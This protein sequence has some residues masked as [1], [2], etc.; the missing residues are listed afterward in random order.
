MQEEEEK[1]RSPLVPVPPGLKELVETFTAPL[2]E[3]S[4]EAP[5]PDPAVS[6]ISPGQSSA[7][8]FVD[9]DD[10]FSDDI[11]SSTGHTYGP[12]L[13]SATSNAIANL[14]GGFARVCGA[15]SRPGPTITFEQRNGL[16]PLYNGGD[17]GSGGRGLSRERSWHSSSKSP[18]ESK[19]GSRVQ[20]T[21]QEYAAAKANG[22]K[23]LG[24]RNGHLSTPNITMACDND[25][26]HND[27]LFTQGSTIAG[28][29]LVRVRCWE[30][31]CRDYTR[32]LIRPLFQGN[33]QRRGSGTSSDAGA[34]NNGGGSGSDDQMS[35]IRTMLDDIAHENPEI[36]DGQGGGGGN[37]DSF[38]SSASLLR[39]YVDGPQNN[40]APSWAGPG[41]TSTIFFPPTAP[42]GVSRSSS[43][44]A[45][46]DMADLASR[47]SLP[48]HS[49]LTTPFSSM[50]HA[51]SSSGSNNPTSLKPKDAREQL[52]SMFS[53]DACRPVCQPISMDAAITEQAAGKGPIMINVH[54]AMTTTVPLDDLGQPSTEKTGDN[55]DGG[56]GNTTTA[57][58]KT[59]A[60]AAA[61]PVTPAKPAARPEKGIKIGRRP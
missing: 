46:A 60:A 45:D 24:L 16:A 31:V 21:A 5:H 59:T 38:G 15:A 49:T 9:E 34:D 19:M 10:I 29:F 30:A 61:A 54:P 41:S 11:M 47:D 1:E 55:A 18:P 26:N 14:N 25:S 58:S 37:A 23:G 12:T 35:N 28:S 56:S 7:C 3:A 42:P 53:M 20:M 33:Q 4:E 57:A 39:D 17:G 52:L 50:L 22:G 8:R 36:L 43:T 32:R 13:P 40:G 2:P 51:S 44:N 48:A 6:G 27:P